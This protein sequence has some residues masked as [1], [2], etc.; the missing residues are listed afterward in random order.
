MSLDEGNLGLLGG[1]AC[2]F[3]VFFIQCIYMGIM[4][5]VSGCTDKRGWNSRDSS[6]SSTLPGSFSLH[7]NTIVMWQYITGLI[8]YKD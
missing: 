8:L 6:Q 3:V 4:V 5:P 7:C 1:S 2:A